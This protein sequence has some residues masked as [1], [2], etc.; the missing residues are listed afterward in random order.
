MRQLLNQGGGACLT[1]AT[2]SGLE[3]GVQSRQWSIATTDFE[4][5]RGVDE[6]HLPKQVGAALLR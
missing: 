1:Y 4:S 5:Q 6:H 2:S 3:W